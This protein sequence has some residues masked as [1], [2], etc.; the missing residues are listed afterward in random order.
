MSYDAPDVDI[1]EYGFP[2]QYFD[3]LRQFEGND[4]YYSIVQ[5]GLWRALES[6]SRFSMRENWDV[7]RLLHNKEIDEAEEYIQEVLEE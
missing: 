5:G 4:P 1:D 6:D 3:E 2:G 7:N